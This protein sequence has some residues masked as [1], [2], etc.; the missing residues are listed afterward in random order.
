[1]YPEMCAQQKRTRK[2]RGEEGGAVGVPE[3]VAPRKKDEGLPMP[4]R[5]TKHEGKKEAVK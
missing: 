5:W 1:M 2:R 3:W 4:R